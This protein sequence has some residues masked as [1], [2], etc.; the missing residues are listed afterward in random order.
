MKIQ[1]V[2]V[3]TEANLATI[4]IYNNLNCISCSKR[5]CSVSCASCADYD[6][7]PKVRVLAFNE[8]LAKPG[9]H[10]TLTVSKRQKLILYTVSF[11]IP[12]ICAVMAYFCVSV[13]T[14][15]ERVKLG[16]ALVAAIIAMLFAAICS[17]KI[18]ENTYDYK[19]SSITKN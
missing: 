19:I 14:D 5:P 11:V 9:D 6:E 16:T 3:A 8:L 10:V 2:V 17:Y 4:E 13:F 1:G 12:I 18:S 7:S 15:Y